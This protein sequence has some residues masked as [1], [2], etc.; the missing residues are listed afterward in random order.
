VGERLIA[1]VPHGHW[2]T[3]KLIAAPGVEGMHG[4]TV[5]DGPVYGDRFDAYVRQVLAPQLRPG[6]LEAL[7]NLSSH[8]TVRVRAL[9]EVSSGM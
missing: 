8:K 6:D 7:A 2:K 4:A 5:A 9:L 1:K 3:T